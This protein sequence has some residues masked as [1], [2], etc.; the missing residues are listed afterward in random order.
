[1]KTRTKD[2]TIK[3]QILSLVTGRGPRQGE[4]PR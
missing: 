4:H 1:M 3:T 2:L